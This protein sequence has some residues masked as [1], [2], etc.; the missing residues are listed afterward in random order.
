MVSRQGGREVYDNINNNGSS[1]RIINNDENLK[2]SLEELYSIYCKLIRRGY[3][4]KMK[5]IIREK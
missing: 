2:E 1:I 3:L 5:E 4:M